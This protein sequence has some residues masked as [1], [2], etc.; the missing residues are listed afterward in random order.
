MVN[1][2][3]PVASGIAGEDRIKLP[4]ADGIV[5]RIAKPVQCNPEM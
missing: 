4:I 3:L 1:E 2:L 5:R